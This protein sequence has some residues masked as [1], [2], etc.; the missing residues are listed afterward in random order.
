MNQ[1]REGKEKKKKEKDSEKKK[2]ER[3]G[4][5]EIWNWE[6]RKKKNR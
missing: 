1:K 5:K 6:E 2:K 4:G 3:K